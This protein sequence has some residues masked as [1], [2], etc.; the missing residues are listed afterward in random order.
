ML[1]QFSSFCIHFLSVYE[2]WMCRG[3]QRGNDSS[4]MC[5]RSNLKMQCILIECLWCYRQR[6]CRPVSLWRKARWWTIETNACHGFSF[7]NLSLIFQSLQWWFKNLHP[8]FMCMAVTLNLTHDVN[9]RIPEYSFQDCTGILE[10][11]CVLPVV[12]GGRYASASWV[13]SH[14]I[15]VFIKYVNTCILYVNDM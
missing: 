8:P 4:L 7:S 9:P 13:G 6:L 11:I 5:Y 2:K 14:I 15:A 10:N 3:F 1:F 12:W